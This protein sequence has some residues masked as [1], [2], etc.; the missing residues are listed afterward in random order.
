[1]TQRACV[2]A[3]VLFPILSHVA[4]A[5]QTLTAKQQEPIHAATSA[6]QRK[7]DQKQESVAAKEE[8]SRWVNERIRTGCGQDAFSY[9][10][11]DTHRG[12]EVVGMYQYR[13]L[14][15]RSERTPLS[16]ADPLNGITWRGKI[17]IAAKLYRKY[18]ATY[19]SF[20][21]DGM[22]WSKWEEFPKDSPITVIQRHEA[23]Q[24]HHNIDSG[25]WFTIPILEEA[26]DCAFAAELAKDGTRK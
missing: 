17:I 2:L 19:G 8:A 11:K 6:Q 23:G 25:R 16:S 13:G 10:S 20:G 3:I 18:E 9:K 7:T 15:W 24:W 1:M 22:K 4:Y 5:Q 21:K 26:P 14:T 12:P